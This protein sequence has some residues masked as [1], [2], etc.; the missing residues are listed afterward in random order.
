MTIKA[1]SITAGK[2]AKL[3][4]ERVDFPFSL[5]DGQPHT[6]VVFNIQTDKEVGEPTEITGFRQ[7]KG[8]LVGN[9]YKVIYLR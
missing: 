2:T 3:D 4:G 8:G 7:G 1:K 5:D 9:V 6:L